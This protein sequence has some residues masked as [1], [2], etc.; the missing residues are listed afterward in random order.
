MTTEEQL[1]I[2]I[3]IHHR[4]ADVF[5]VSRES[6][7]ARRRH[8]EIAEAKF[9]ACLVCRRAMGI[10]FNR[11]SAMFGD[12]SQSLFNHRHKRAEALM[13]VDQA[14]RAKVDSILRTIT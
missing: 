5:G 10:S 11:L 2:V 12:K 3:A 13:D 8:R 6:M 9:A 1:S 14:F 7:L 4:V